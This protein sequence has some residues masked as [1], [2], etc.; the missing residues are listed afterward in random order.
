MNLINWL[1]PKRCVS[2][3]RVGQYLCSDCV[4]RVGTAEQACPMCG[5]G[6]IYGLTHVRCRRPHGIDG[7][8]RVFKYRGVVK[9]MIGKI[10]YKLVTDMVT[11]LVEAI[12]SLGDFTPLTKD[13]WLIVPVPL[14]ASRLRWRGFNQAE[15]VARH[16]AHYFGWRHAPH[17]LIRTKNTTPQVGLSGKARRANLRGAFALNPKLKASSLKHNANSILLVDDVSTTGTTLR[18]CAKV[19]KAAGVGKVWG[20]VV[21]G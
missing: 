1:F 7:L 17:L 16:L 12:I 4:N 21:A 10:K 6:S 20:L 5:K 18:E 13:T 2:C 14:H 3:G 15:V 9:I 19:L 8:V 11:E